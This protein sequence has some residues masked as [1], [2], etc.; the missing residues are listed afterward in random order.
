MQTAGLTLYAGAVLY[1][2]T[3]QN[4][5][6]RDRLAEKR[7]GGGSQF[8]KTAMFTR[9]RVV[10]NATGGVREVPQPMIGAVPYTASRLVEI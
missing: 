1:D 7:R 6:A 10:V 4:T 9:R 8:V 2:L 3:R 5:G